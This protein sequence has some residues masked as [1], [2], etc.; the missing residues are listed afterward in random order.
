MPKVSE[1]KLPGEGAGAEVVSGTGRVLVV[2]DDPHNRRLLRLMLAQSGYEIEE[3]TGGQEAIDACRTS[4]PDLILM[5]VMMPGVDGY[6]ATRVIKEEAGEW[7]VPVIFLTALD[8]EESLLRGIESGGDDFLSKP[9]NL[10]ILKAKIH[11]MERLR[12]LQAGLR[13]RNEALARAQARQAWEEETAESLFSRAITRRNVGLDHIRVGHLSAATFS[14]DV[15]LADFTPEGGLRVLLGDFTGHG[16][17]AAIGAYPVSET[18]HTLTAEGA[19]DCELLHELNHVLHDFLPPTM[20]MA[21][22]LLTFEPDGR[23]LHVWNGGMPDV[24]ICEHGRQVRRVSSWAMP[25]G[26][27]ARLDLDSGPRCEA[28]ATAAGILLVSDGVTEAVNEAGE[29]FGEDRLA[30]LCR[31]ELPLDALFAT[32]W[33]AAEAHRGDAPATDDMTLVAIPCAAGAIQAGTSVARGA[34][35]GTLRWSLEAADAQLEVT[36]L[37]AE[38]RYQLRRWFPDLGE[39]VQPLYT[40]I[41]ELC[42]NAF[43]HGVLGL[44]SEMKSTT[45]GFERYYRARAEG[46]RD[47]RGRIAVSLAYRQLGGQHCMRIRVRDSGPGFDHAVV[48]E[49]IEGQ[50]ER[51]LWGR[52]LTLV[53]QL[54]R[55]VRHLGNGNVVE[56]DYCW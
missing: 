11:A 35:P 3:V 48:R 24:W 30:A 42:N 50:S 47:M 31:D 10:A 38:A 9:L 4:L 39:H 43:E 20:F 26:I 13:R 52:G 2:D 19:S 6:Q 27:L 18:F 40:V 1:D 53:H 14:G 45:E 22:V 37:A 25:L 5:D 23:V 36:D 56:A 41:S 49:M 51:R 21:A 32:L 12:D 55:Q 28:I 34:L 8:D 44:D 29:A 7:F 33:E 16:L 46:L 15:V 17:A 54:C